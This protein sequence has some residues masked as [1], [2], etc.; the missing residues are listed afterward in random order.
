MEDDC[1]LTHL[2]GDGLDIGNFLKEDLNMLYQGI[3]IVVLKALLEVLLLIGI[4]FLIRRLNLI[5]SSGVQAIA[6]L[7][8]YVCLPS[9][10]FYSFLTYLNRDNLWNCGIFLLASF[11]IFGLGFVLAKIFYSLVV[12]NSDVKREF[13]LLTAFQNSGY[14]PLAL[15]S[16]IFSPSLKGMGYLYIF[17]YLI[18]FNL[19]M[20]SFGFYYMKKTHH[21]VG[22]KELLPFPF[23]VSIISVFLALI[24]MRNHV[25]DFLLDSLRKLG[26]ATIP[27]GMIVVG[28]LLAQGKLV[29][30]NYIKP[31]VL[32]IALR[33]LL[34]PLIVGAVLYF[35]KLPKFISFLI[36]LEA[37]MPSATTLSLIASD[38]NANVEFVSQGILYTHIFLIVSLPV[39][40]MVFRQYG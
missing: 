7:L 1:Q 4:G 2:S 6:R 20:L 12:R 24:G 38:R 14:L 8:L 26:E 9:L 29:S 19:I 25:P 3:N 27:L 36:F 37:A 35:L 39:L 31:T 21:R 11:G 10:I 34:L 18:G 40:L 33:L 13:V 15:I 28:L 5:S 23:I 30:R 17:S 32:L 22:F 16:G